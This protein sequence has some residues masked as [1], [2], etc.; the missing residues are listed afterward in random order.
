[1]VRKSLLVL[2]LL[3]P[4]TVFAQLVE[5]IEVRITNLDV[6]VTD[7]SG[8]PVTGLTQDDFVVVENGKEQPVTNF[9]EIR[10][11]AGKGEAPD[12]APEVPPAVAKRRIVVFVDNY[13]IHPLARNQAFAALEKSMS[14]IIRDGDE[15]MIVF[16]NR[17]LEIV[18]PF[19][20]DRA[21]LLRRFRAAAKESSGGMSLETTRTRILNHAS[22]MLADAA[23]PSQNKISVPRAYNESIASA[24]DFAEEVYAIE[25]Q[26]LGDLS[27][28]IGTLAGVEGKKAMIFL[29]AELPDQPGLEVF[30]QIDALFRGHMRIDRP[31]FFREGGKRSLGADMRKVARQ[32]N[33]NGVTMYMVDTANRSRRNDPTEGMVDA[34]ADFFAQTNTPIAMSTIAA[35]TGGV[36]VAGGKSFEQALGTIS[37]D[38]SSYYSLGYRSPDAGEGN[39]N[40]EVRVKRDGLRVRSR[41]TY[42]ARTPEEDVRERVIANVFHASVKSDFDIDV[43]A[44]KPERQADGQFRLPLTIHF[45]SSMTLIP[46]DGQLAGEFAVYIATG[47]DTGSV[48]EVTKNVQP[49]KFPAGSEKAILDMK[50][51]TYQAA[52]LVREGEQFVSVA[53]VDSVAGSAGFAR[54]KVTAK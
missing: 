23:A 47:T 15:A 17:G 40:V 30:Q 24:R 9:Y 10:G 20:S 41:S 8:R 54:E 45:P 25:V 33:A 46:Q 27:R 3:L 39:R 42:I 4:T 22:Q 13:T 32:A 18:A 1:M 21:E 35:I 34:S 51:F 29:G 14:Q 31:A 12:A 28:M 52:L 43:V 50:T 53:V 16:W 6:V 48:S 26:M 44:G 11:T 49:M 38:L 2:A 5:T 19:T 36:S 7:A 37:D